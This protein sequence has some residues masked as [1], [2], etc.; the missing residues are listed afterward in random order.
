MYAIEARNISKIFKRHRRKFY[1][2]E[3]VT[4]KVRENEIFAL[5]GPNGSGKTT[6]IG[7]LLTLI[8][9]DEGSIKIFGR[10]PFEEHEVLERV[11]YLPS[12]RPGGNIKVKDFIEG[13][14]R[15]YGVGRR[16]MS[17]VVSELKLGNLMNQVLWD[18]SLGEQSRLLLAKC[19]LNS[20]KLLV[21]DEP[22]LGLD[23]KSALEIRR[24]LVELNKKG[25]TIFFTSHNMN[26]VAK[27]AERVAF[28]REGRILDVQKT[29]KI[30]K[31]YASL[32]NYWL[33]LVDKSG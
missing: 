2:L 5:L 6:F 18:L 25:C 9:P 1:A 26:E 19:M 4:L 33:K 31:R 21:L 20:P 10:N 28:I 22:M 8:M 15:I 23:P 17:R 29:S 14:A 24:K 30:I 12:R 11:N 16:K 7:V 32:E 3:R 13:F 27:L